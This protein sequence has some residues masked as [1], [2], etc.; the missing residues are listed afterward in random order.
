MGFRVL[1]VAVVLMCW[2]LPISAQQSVELVFDAGRVTLRSQNVS[3]RVILAEW[4][5]LGGVTIVNGDRVAGPP[6]TLEL[7]G[8]PEQ[9]ALDIILRSVAGYVLAPRRPGS[10]SA[11]AFDRV[12]ILA[13]S[14]APNNP[15]PPPVAAV[16][17]PPTPGVRTVLRSPPIIVRQ[18]PVDVAAPVGGQ[19]FNPLGPGAPSV[20]QQPLG[21]QPTA[22]PGAELLDHA[23]LP[24]SLRPPQ[25]PA[26][27]GVAPTPSN[28]FGI[29]PFGSSATPGV[30]TPA[31]DP[32][33][34]RQTAYNSA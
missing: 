2:A 31:P 26:P 13:S 12:L 8:V 17:A 25:A 18:P 7:T 22:P 16:A 27:T 29:P 19:P 33:P 4:A 5:R 24:P 23:N 1:A 34:P 6:L 20:V 11:S 3:A 21:D 9:Q 30:V 32:Q 14:A 15:P 28:P 10:D